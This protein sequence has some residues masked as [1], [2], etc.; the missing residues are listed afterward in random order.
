MTTSTPIPAAHRRIAT[1]YWLAAVGW[2]IVAVVIGWMLRYSMSGSLY[3]GF[4]FK[5]W[6]HA[7]SHLAFLG[8][9][10]NALIGLTLWSFPMQ[11]KG[12]WHRA[13]FWLAQISVLGMLLTFPGNG[14]YLWSIVVS[15]LHIFVSYVMA[16]RLIRDTYDNGSPWI[17]HATGW[18][19]WAL[20]FMVAS[21]IG[22][23][24]LGMIMAQGAEDTI[25]YKLSI[26]FY[27]HFQYNGWF[28]L[29]ALALVMVWMARK[30][31]ARQV[32]P[33]VR[34]L[35]I[36]VS[37]VLLTYAQSA[38]W[39]N[40]PASVVVLAWLGGGLQLAGIF[41]LWKD[42]W[43][44]FRQMRINPFARKLLGVAAFAITLKIVLQLLAVV[45]ALQ[46]FSSQHQVA[47]AFLHLVFLGGL[48]PFLF[49]QAVALQL[50]RPFT[51]WMQLA[52]TV[53][54][55]AFAGMELI[56]VIPNIIGT[57]PRA[58]INWSDAML[59]ITSLMAA[60]L[61]IFL[62]MAQQKNLRHDN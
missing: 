5:H 21:S 41:Y 7:H 20:F 56:L 33:S 6:L 54:L 58:L 2:F 49:G 29:Q 32:R 27:L 28:I 53:F 24:L 36:L 61:L 48:T 52:S 35:W 26:Y 16:V 31:S 30:N 10:Y 25:W 39:T 37:G 46:P 15:T 18:M 3:D 62:F 44:V 60:A 17:K 34:S 23:Y 57:W 4:V 43:P 50:I 12:K 8:W 19:K 45:P 1:W 9:I 13:L 11:D 55:A 40:P 22:P 14:Y 51:G 59:W 47:I 42:W 38:L